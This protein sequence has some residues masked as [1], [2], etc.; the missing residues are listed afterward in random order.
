MLGS[1]F[2]SRFLGGVFNNDSNVL[3]FAFE[4]N[5]SGVGSLEALIVAVPKIGRKETI[6]DIRAEYPST[7]VKIVGNGLLL[8][9]SGIMQRK[10]AKN[11]EVTVKLVSP[12]ILQ[13]ELLNSKKPVL[14]QN[15]QFSF[16]R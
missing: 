12:L 7:R 5:I 14:E 13:G 8:D 4:G 9:L 6:A 10:L 16:R 3:R 2:P 1:V 11:N 15:Y